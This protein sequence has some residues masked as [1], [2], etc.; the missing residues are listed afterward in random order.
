MF[1]LRAVFAALFFCMALAG[2]ATVPSA[3]DSAFSE[4]KLGAFIE[5]AAAVSRLRDHWTPQINAA[6]D[7]AAANGLIE[8]ANNQIR[9]AIV[10][11]D[12]ISLDEYMTITQAAEQDPALASRLEEMFRNKVGQ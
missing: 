3:Q 1:Q 11:T 4:A 10:R 5:A 12:G 8:Q 7:E 6:P 2:A 9:E